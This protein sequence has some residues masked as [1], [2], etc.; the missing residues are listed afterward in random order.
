MSSSIVINNASF[1]AWSTLAAVSR[2]SIASASTW[3]ASTAVSIASVSTLI[4]SNTASIASN[5]ALSVEPK[6]TTPIVLDP[7]GRAATTSTCISLPSIAL[8]KSSTAVSIASVSTLIVSSTASIAVNNTS[9][10]AW[11]VFAEVNNTSI[12][13]RSTT[14][15]SRTALSVELKLAVTVPVTATSLLEPRFTRS[16]FEESPLA[17]S[18]VEPS[19]TMPMDMIFVVDGLEKLSADVAAAGNSESTVIEGIV[20]TSTC[21]SFPSIALSNISTAVLIAFVSESIVVSN[22]S[23]AAWSVLAEVK[24]T[25][26]AAKSTTIASNTALSVLPRFAVTVPSTVIVPS[27]AVLIAS[28]SESIVPNK[29]CIALLVVS[30]V[31]KLSL[32]WAKFVLTNAIGISSVAITTLWDWA[33]LLPE[34]PSTSVPAIFKLVLR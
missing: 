12:A 15:A 32:K 2:V 33:D 30:K 26:I 22:T 4:V 17:L 27:T 14:I 21:I 1:A 31:S 23:L 16:P 34:P 7:E 5:T 19:Y 13:A 24:S 25:S 18:Q 9:L 3:I 29:T 20:T 28:V 6:S 11:S 10:A 8:S